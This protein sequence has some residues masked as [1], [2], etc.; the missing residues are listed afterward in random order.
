M[1]QES[2]G[3]F[4]IEELN[5]FTH[6][7]LPMCNTEGKSSTQSA[8]SSYGYRKC[9]DSEFQKL[10]LPNCSEFALECDQKSEFLKTYKIRVCTK[11]IDGF[12]EKKLDF[13]R[14]VKVRKFAIECVSNEIIS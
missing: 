12:L 11:K 5:V 6:Y 9:P 13:F 1:T 2:V 8:A 4:Y 7:F 3:C 10:S 14:N